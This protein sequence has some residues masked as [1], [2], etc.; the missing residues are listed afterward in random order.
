MGMRANSCMNCVQALS[1]DQLKA[2]KHMTQGFDIS[3]QIGIYDGDT[4][5][6]DRTWMRDNARLVFV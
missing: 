3:S 5:Q 6:G 1:Q 2:L 4:L